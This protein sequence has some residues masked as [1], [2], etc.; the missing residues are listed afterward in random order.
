MKSK[1][2]QRVR[3]AVAGLGHLAQIAALPAFKQCPNAES[4]GAGLRRSSKTEKL[5]AKYGIDKVYSYDRYEECLSNGVDAVYI[6][7]AAESPSQRIH[8]A[9]AR[10]WRACVVRE[11][12]GG[13]GRGMRSDDSGGRRE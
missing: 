5:V 6:G 7:C 1:K 3:Y 8:G 9:R 10:C 2:G 11:A 4:G 12:D 13:H